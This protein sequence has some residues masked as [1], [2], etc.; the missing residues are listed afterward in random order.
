[1]KSR[2]I[3]GS[4]ETLV[5]GSWSVNDGVRDK[6]AALK[7]FRKKKERKKEKRNNAPGW[8][9][10]GNR[11]AEAVRSA[12]DHVIQKA[13]GTA[14]YTSPRAGNGEMITK[15]GVRVMSVIV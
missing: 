10:C 15:P 6:A 4:T 5:R 13:R 12:A 14:A 9:C 11:R 7:D 8:P 3:S 2:E 1:M